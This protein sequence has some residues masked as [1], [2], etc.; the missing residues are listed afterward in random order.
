MTSSYTRVIRCYHLSKTRLI[1]SKR[2]R[3]SILQSCHHMAISIR[4]YCGRQS[5][6]CHPNSFQIS[7]LVNMTLCIPISPWC[8]CTTRVRTC[9]SQQLWWI[10][11]RYRS[12]I[13]WALLSTKQVWRS[14]GLSSRLLP[15]TSVLTRIFRGFI[16]HQR[17]RIL[18]NHW[19]RHPVSHH[20][21]SQVQD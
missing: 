7:Q 20:L 10:L 17:V 18:L 16:F 9:M 5:T 11:S 2:V 6:E 19:N 21:R 15:W 3:P 1:C 12:H 14:K 13:P 8:R 4:L